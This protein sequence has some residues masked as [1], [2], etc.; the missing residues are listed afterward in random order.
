MVENEIQD[1]RNRLM[2]YEYDF[3][4]WGVT[5]R[6]MEQAGGA[7]VRQLLGHEMAVFSVD[8]SSDG[9]FVVFGAERIFKISLNTYRA[10]LFHVSL[11]FKNHALYLVHLV[12]QSFSCKE[13][14][15]QGHG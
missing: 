2:K 3:D 9:R 12:F 11:K 6:T 10:N 8:Y 5:S 4:W 15:R 13:L 14:L 7:C 1:L